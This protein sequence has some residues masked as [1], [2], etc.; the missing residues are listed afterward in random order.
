[1][2]SRVGT[3]DWVPRYDMEADFLSRTNRLLDEACDL[4]V[5]DKVLKAARASAT[6]ETLAGDAEAYSHGVRLYGAVCA[7]LVA[8]PLAEKLTRRDQEELLVKEMMIKGVMSIQSGDNP[9][10]VEQKLTIFLP[11]SM[12]EAGKWK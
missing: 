2:Y 1:M 6:E 11:P 4:W 5:E 8:T 10:I 12:R 7:Y 9:R 3:D